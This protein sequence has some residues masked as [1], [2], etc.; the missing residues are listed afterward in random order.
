MEN[1]PGTT[2]LAVLIDGDNFPANLADSLFAQVGMLGNA[3]IR[4]VY[5]TSRAIANWRGAAAKYAVALQEVLPGS[6][7]ADM[8]LV[9]DAM[10]ILHRGKVDGFCI[11]SSDSDFAELARRLREDGIIVHGFGG[12]SASAELAQA[13][14]DFVPLSKPAVKQAAAT[15]PKVTTEANPQPVPVKKTKAAPATKPKETAAAQSSQAITRKLL[16]RAIENLNAKNT[17]PT[18]VAIGQQLMRLEA[19]FSCKKHGASSIK[20]LA[21]NCGLEVHKQKKSWVVTVPA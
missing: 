9:I 6:N 21:I 15:K 10:D 14:D 2:R 12:S 5:G 7:A 1:T 13:C 4:R 3:G 17:T 11:V 20:A 19:G 16:E 8:R 18:L